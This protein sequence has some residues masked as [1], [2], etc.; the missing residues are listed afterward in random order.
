[1]LKRRNKTKINTNLAC[2]PGAMSQ[3]LGFTTKPNSIDL[4]GTTIWIEDVGENYTEKNIISSARIG[5]AYAQDHA[6]WPYRFYIKNHD[7]VSKKRL[8]LSK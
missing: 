1:M 3:A 6:L 8:F 7:W 2:G 5:V 4:M